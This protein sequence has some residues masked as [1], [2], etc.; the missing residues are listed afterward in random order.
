MRN[1]DSGSSSTSERRGALLALLEQARFEVLPLP[2][3]EEAVLAHVPR[4][5]ML[6]VTASP[7]QGL[8][9]TLALTERLSDAGY[10]AVPHLAARMIQDRSELQEICDRLTGRGVRR[11]FVPGGDAEAIGDYAD[12]LALVAD[13]TALGSPF[14][15]VGITAYPESHPTIPD[16]MT[17]QS[18]WD[19]RHHATEIVSNLTFD[20][21]VLTTW[22]RRVRRRG[23]TMPLW[24][25]VPGPVDR[26]RLLTTATRIGVGESTRFL[27]KHHRVLARLGLPGGF[28]GERFLTA[29][30]PALSRPDAL[31]TGLHVYTFN[32]VA[33]TESWCRDLAARLR[34]SGALPPEGLQA[35]DD[36]DHHHVAVY[37]DAPTDTNLFPSRSA[38]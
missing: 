28:T 25:G 2:S 16:D 22:L 13:L 9:A 20:A 31:V 18:M 27:V 21:D 38:S 3:A 37:R 1:T 7:R 11:V 5:R 33:Q 23:I 6:T 34:R 14:A 15:H 24:V 10:T 30:A 12:A 29:A 8:E 17:I 4:S 32:Q 36:P 35:P 26:R 19:K